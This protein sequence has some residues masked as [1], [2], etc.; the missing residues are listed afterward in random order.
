[1]MKILLLLILMVQLAG[2]LSPPA[3]KARRLPLQKKE[4]ALESPTNY[5]HRIIGYDPKTNEPVYYDPKPRVTLLDAKS[6][7]YGLRWI[8]YDGKEK[9]IVYQRP[10][11]L[12]VIVSATV[13]K[14]CN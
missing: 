9:T 5:V 11:A 12:E 7:K 4:I 14:G 2:A 10:D 6:G 1:M 3:Q 13:S 8:G